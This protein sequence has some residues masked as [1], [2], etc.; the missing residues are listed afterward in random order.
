MAVEGR[1]ASPCNIVMPGSIPQA[2]TWGALFW[3]S[4]WGGLGGG[5]RQ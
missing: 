5:E 4:P 2:L 3:P 1:G